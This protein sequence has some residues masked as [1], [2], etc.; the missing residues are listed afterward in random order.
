LGFAG[1]SF[2]TWS[3][4]GFLCG[5]CEVVRKKGGAQA[6]LGRCYE[7]ATAGCLSQ[8]AV[9]I[10]RGWDL[11]VKDEVPTFNNKQVSDT[12]DILG[13]CMNVDIGRPVE[14]EAQRARKDILQSPDFT[15]RVRVSLQSANRCRPRWSCKWV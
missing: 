10:S 14:P 3:G 15:T 5:K 1:H 12:L 9:F 11:S 4:K 6:G 2:S 7:L 8:R 13:A